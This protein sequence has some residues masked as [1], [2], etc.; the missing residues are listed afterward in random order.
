MRSKQEVHSLAV[1]L[2]N[3][4]Q[5]TIFIIIGI[6]IVVA[7]ILFLILR[8]GITSEKIP[9]DFQAPYTSFL[10]C[11]EDDSLTGISL[12]ESQGGYIELP[13][14]ESGSDYM[15]FSSQLNFVG[16]NIPYWYYV[17]GNN[18][19]REQV[20]SKGNMESQLSGF[21]NERISDCDLSGYSGDYEISLGNPRT[22]VT[23]NNKNVDVELSM[24]LNMAKA[25]ENV[26]ID[27]HSVVVNSKLG[28]LY[29]DAKTVYN[30]EQEELFLE[31]Y[32]V[33][34]LRLYAPVDGVEIT[35]SPLTWNAEKIFDGLEEA[36]EANTLALKGE[37]DVNDYYFVDVG[38]ENVRFINSRS[39]PRSFE[40]LPGDGPIL[41]AN[42]VGNQPGLGI[43]GF[44]YV[45][46]HFVYNVN[47]P[48]LIQIQ[49]GEEIFQFPVAIVIQR[50]NP[51]ESLSYITNEIENPE[52][53]KYKN[54]E[55]DVFTR[56]TNRELID[57]SV[58]YEC[59][60]TVCYIG[61][62]SNGR[63]KTEFPQCIN[64]RVVARAE[65]YRDGKTTFSSVDSGSVD[66]FLDK[67]Y[68]L[69]VTLNLDGRPYDGKAI[70]SFV[71][72]DSSTI[73]YP[74]QNVVELSQGEYEIQVYIYEDSSLTLGAS[75]Q[76]ECIE[77]LK[78]GIGGILGL[79][80]EKCFEIEIPEQIISSALSGG[81]KQSYYFLES[82]LHG[83]VIDINA[84]SL[85]KPNSLEQLQ[86]NYILFEDRGLDIEVR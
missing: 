47:Y 10:S 62:S 41:I 5:V 78:G 4:G 8:G 54:T 7:V 2:K 19:Q 30:K 17:S 83:K 56:N 14:Y 50:N 51:R 21:I 85:P 16:T 76:E 55:V 43:L 53:C 23:I 33:D 75:V 15:P 52:I 29:E 31:N 67:I 12:L 74:E 25:E 3:K 38:V 86:I 20:P 28:K 61:E 58:S 68:P 57:A 13:D 39:W 36:I 48:V 32:G 71:S 44:C 64:G 65:G 18:I 63:L 24:D 35:C 82:E 73:L 72:N 26:K 40:V 84:R 22:R 42:P 9:A 1:R 27:S 46:Y 6:V 11:L 34:I 59:S 69:E 37:G 60:S 66:V 81:G 45:P 77:V 80:E 79:K 70:I 49:D